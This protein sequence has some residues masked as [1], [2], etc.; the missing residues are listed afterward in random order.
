[1]TDSPADFD[2]VVAR[3]QHLLDIGRADDALAMLRADQRTATDAGALVTIA[4]CHLQL[5]DDGDAAEAAEQSVAVD[6][7]RPGGWMMLALA[8]LA[9]G[10]PVDAVPPA[11]RGVELA[12][13][14]PGAHTVAARVYGELGRFEPALHHAHKVLELDP[15]GPAGWIALCRVQIAQQRWDEAAMAANE[16]L[17]R[18]P[19]SKEARVLLGAAQANSSHANGRAKAME[20]LATTLRDNPDADAIR[21]FLIDVALNSRPKPHVW[22]PIIVV[23]I[24]ATGVGL[25]IFL[26]VWTATLIQTWQSIPSDIQRL[27]L[28]DR[29]ARSKILAVGIV[30]AAL[31]LFLLAGVVLVLVDVGGA[32]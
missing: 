11:R 32:A 6:P 7:E 31:W 8:R 4:H 25:L 21:Q 13:W 27:V 22:L 18:D 3:A 26:S 17:G 24:F 20:T 29:K 15:D 14:F 5:D 9:Q 30:V 16:A 28:A 1:M 2:T 10:R 23:S 19:E 12:P